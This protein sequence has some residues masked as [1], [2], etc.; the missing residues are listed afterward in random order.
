[1][2]SRRAFLTAFAATLASAVLPACGQSPAWIGV[3]AAAKSRDL[4]ITIRCDT[5]IFIEQLD[6]LLVA[7]SNRVPPGFDAMI[8]N[9]ECEIELAPTDNKTVYQLQFKPGGEYERLMRSATSDQP[10]FQS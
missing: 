10:I 6:R 8:R 3:D 1:M 4:T 2:T 7:I 9:I 5:S